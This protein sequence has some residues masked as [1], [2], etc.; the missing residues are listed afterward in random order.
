[1]INFIWGFCF[2]LLLVIPF[3]SFSVTKVRIKS[4]ASGIDRGWDLAKEFFLN[5]DKILE[6]REKQKE[7]I[8][9]NTEVNNL[10]LK[11]LKF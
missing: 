3:L 8:L 9:S 4:Y 10:I 11:I 1:M 2:C 6:I 7:G 5:I